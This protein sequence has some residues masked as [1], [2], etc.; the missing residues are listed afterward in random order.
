M[1]TKLLLTTAFAQKHSPPKDFVTRLLTV[2]AQARMSAEEATTHPW[3]LA[4][5]IS[6]EEHD[7]RC[8]LME[9]KILNAKRK[10][11]SAVKTVRSREGPHRPGR[12]PR[13]PSALESFTG[14]INLPAA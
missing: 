5:E 7:L 8:G 12:T 14:S 1:R 13:C 11:R 4:T 10:L 6:L 3:I 2:D 9:L